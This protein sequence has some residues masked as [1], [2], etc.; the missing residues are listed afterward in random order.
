MI[1]STFAR[2]TLRIVAT[3]TVV[4]AAVA[5]QSTP[6]TAPLPIA[7]A[8]I[9]RN[10]SPFDI[11]VYAVAS[12]GGR[13]WLVTVPAKGLRSLP[14]EARMLRAGSELVV[15][16][17]SIGASAKWTSNPVAVGATVF[18]MLDLTTTSAG[19][20]SESLLYPITASELRAAMR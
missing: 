9:V 6:R 20:C 15:E 2:T 7:S 8:L 11:N 1:R 10:P 14:V 12:D 5:C 17:Q 4:L 3:A 19:D 16:T 13:E 18:A